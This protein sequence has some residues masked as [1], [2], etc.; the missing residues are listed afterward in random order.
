MLVAVPGNSTGACARHGLLRRLWAPRSHAR[1]RP[2][3]ARGQAATI[4][5]RT[6]TTQRMR[7]IW[8]CSRSCELTRQWVHAAM[9][10]GPKLSWDRYHKGIWWAKGVLT[11][12]PCMEEGQAAGLSRMEG[13][14]HQADGNPFVR[15]LAPPWCYRPH[16]WRCISCSACPK[17]CLV[18]LRNWPRLSHP[19]W[20]RV[21]C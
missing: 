8:A 10:C 9:R 7:G 12:P 2:K 6:W 19:R 11:L 21:S 5:T 1:H 16:A 18:P 13:H 4:G 14:W 20:L 17:A 3:L 15:P